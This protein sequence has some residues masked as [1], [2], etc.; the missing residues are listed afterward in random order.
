MAPSHVV[1]NHPVTGF[2][3][4]LEATRATF[5]L[6]SNHLPSIYPAFSQHSTLWPRF[7][8]FRMPWP[9]RIFSPGLLEGDNGTII[10][11]A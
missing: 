8:F 1:M 10:D 3:K 4:E 11:G 9:R 2:L 6:N 7:F 5:F